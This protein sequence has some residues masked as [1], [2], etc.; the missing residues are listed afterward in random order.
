MRTR[1]S[2]AILFLCFFTL[3]ASPQKGKVNPW[4]GEWKLDPARSSGLQDSSSA[5]TIHIT[6]A[7]KSS[8]R[9]TVGGG[10]NGTAVL[11]SYDGK[12]DG[13]PHPLL[14]NGKVAGSVSYRWKSG[15][16]VS[17]EITYPD[18][19]KYS[20]DAELSKDLKTLTLKL[21]PITSGHGEVEQTLV[22]TRQ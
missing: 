22:Y 8:I 3:A 11:E 13:Q 18:G 6:A 21:H 16:I 2:F 9:Y 4:L 5:D 14:M 10:S 15:K 1:I 17:S 12:A 7:D 20:E 19:S